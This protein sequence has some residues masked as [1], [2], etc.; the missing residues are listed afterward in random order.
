M[1]ET[2]R[3][4]AIKNEPA[5]AAYAALIRFAAAQA[6]TFSLT[7]RHQLQ[8]DAA[9]KQLEKALRPSLIRHHVTDTWP[10]TQ[11]VGHAAVVRFYSLS[12]VAQRVLDD[13]TRL[14]A[15]RAP[16]RPEDLAFYTQAG[17]WWLASIAHEQQS[18]I[19][20]V[21][22]DVSRLLAA[23]PGLHLAD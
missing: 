6:S 20:P 1:P 8:F 22:V 12:P 19:D 7:W 9:A 15:W 14:Y 21:G 11:L 13:V 3:T 2:P 18:F 23:V 5:A 16:G 17:R 4:R 10:G